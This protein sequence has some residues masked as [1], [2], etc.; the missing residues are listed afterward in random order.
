MLLVFHWR[1]ILMSSKQMSF[2]ELLQSLVKAGR[3]MFNM[4]VARL[5]ATGRMVLEFQSRTGGRKY[6]LQVIDDTLYHIPVTS[7]PET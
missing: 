4:E 5:P 1:W 6:R 7:P 2:E 3:T